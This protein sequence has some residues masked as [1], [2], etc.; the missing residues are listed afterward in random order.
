MT[1]KPEGDIGA[2]PE[3]SLGIAEQPDNTVRRKA[4][5]VSCL[6]AI[7]TAGVSVVPGKADVCSDPDEAC[8]ISDDVGPDLIRRKTVGGRQ[9]VEV[10]DGEEL[11]L[12]GKKTPT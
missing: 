1:R 8:A 11:V 7:D 10:E 12:G 3:T 6:M 4:V 9:A 5:R 2:H